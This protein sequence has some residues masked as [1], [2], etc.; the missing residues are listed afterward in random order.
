MEGAP[1]VLS[2]TNADNQFNADVHKITVALLQN[3]EGP[4]ANRITQWS[5]F[6]LFAILSQFCEA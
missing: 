3:A 5:R 4:T 1:T 6:G 2:T